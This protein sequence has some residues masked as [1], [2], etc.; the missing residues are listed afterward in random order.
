M[1][2]PLPLSTPVA[3]A[4][5]S[6]A[7]QWYCLWL[8]DSVARQQEPSVRSWLH[9]GVCIMMGSPPPSKKQEGRVRA[10][11]EAPRI[12]NQISIKRLCTVGEHL[13]TE[14]HTSLCCYIVV[15]RSWV[16]L[17]GLPCGGFYQI[18]TRLSS[19]CKGI[20][21]VKSSSLGVP[22]YVV[23]VAIQ[24]GHPIDA[25]K[26]THTQHRFFIPPLP[27]G[28][29]GFRT[30]PPPPGC[31]SSTLLLAGLMEGPVRKQH[32]ANE[33]HIHQPPHRHSLTH[34]PQQATCRAPVP[35]T[36]LYPPPGVE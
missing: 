35:T 15:Q 26:G 22:K 34:S 2:Q 24:I 4:S 25:L 13:S 18:C 14:F 32:G 1:G 6:T 10:T 29:K 16:A 30:W 11:R 20:P 9:P 33:T 7:R 19:Q 8:G 3:C 17:E 5:P 28:G 12:S 31:P 23:K 36:L 27:E 21:C